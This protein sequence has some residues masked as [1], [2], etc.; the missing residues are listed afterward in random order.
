MLGDLTSGTMFGPADAMNPNGKYRPYLSYMPV[1]LPDRSW[2]GQQITKA[3]TWCSVDL[4][5]GNQALIRPMDFDQ[6]LQLF[7]LL[8]RV[9]FREIEIGFPSANDVEFGFARHLIENGLL[10]NDVWPQV[11]TQARGALIKKTF[12]AIKGAER[13]IVHVYNPTSE[14][15]RRI[16]YRT[17]AAGV[18]ATAVEAVQLIRALADDTDSEIALEYSPES[19]TATEL[20]VALD[21]CN[22][23]VDAWEPDAKRPLILNL[24][25]TVELSTPNI[26]A[27][28]IEWFC[29]NVNSRSSLSISLH[30]HNDRGTAVAAT[31][32][33]L[34]AG[35]DRVEGTLFGNGERTGN[36]DLVTVAMNLF[37]QGINPGLDFREMK[38][39]V[40]TVTE[41]NSIPVHPRHP[42]AGQ[43]VFTAFSGSHQF[44]IDRGLTHRSL[45]SA[46]RWDVPYL[47]I[48]PA[49]IGRDYEADA[50]RI[51]NQ[52]GGYGVAHVLR[53]QY[54]WH[55][56]K[57]L[58]REFTDTVVKSAGD[59]DITDELGARFQ[60]EYIQQENPYG[61]V[62]FTVESADSDTD[63]VICCLTV[64]SIA[65]RKLLH[66]RGKSPLSA[67]H[68]ALLLSGCIA[69]E[70]VSCHKHSTNTDADRQSIAYVQIETQD[71]RRRFGAGIDI[72]A[73]RATAKALLS[74]LNRVSEIRTYVLP[75]FKKA[76]ETEYHCRIPRDMET[77]FE[78]C[79]NLIPNVSTSDLPANAIWEAFRNE[80]VEPDGPIRFVD[81]QVDTDHS[82]KDAAPV[83]CQLKLV[84]DGETKLVYGK[85]RG[86]IEACINA[87]QG[88]ELGEQ[89]S[90]LEVF[91]DGYKAQTTGENSDVPAI[92]FVNIAVSGRGRRYGV[93]I[94]SSTE[95]AEVKA[96]I[97]ALNRTLQIRV[98]K[99]EEFI[100]L[101]DDSFSVRIP[102]GMQ[103][104]FLSLMNQQLSREGKPFSTKWVWDQFLGEF[105]D[106][107]SP[108]EFVEFNT[109]PSDEF[110]GKKVCELVLKQNGMLTSLRGVGVGALDAA[111]NAI[112]NGTNDR[113]AYLSDF[114]ILDFEE[115]AKGAGTNAEAIAFVSIDLDHYAVKYGVG[116]HQ[117]TATA[118]VKALIAAV[119][120]SYRKQEYCEYELFEAMRTEFGCELPDEMYAEF[121]DVMQSLVGPSGDPI[122]TRLIWDRFAEEY[123][124]RAVPY[125]VVKSIT[126]SDAENNDLDVC[127]LALDVEGKRREGVG[128]GRNAVA[129]CQDALS[130]C[131]F[132]NFEMIYFGEHS[133]NG[134]GE[135]SVAYVQ[136]EV[137]GQRR[138]FGVGIGPNSDHASVKAVVSAL[139]RVHT[140]N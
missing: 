39:I 73:N 52:S 55:V 77:E 137:T 21:V 125:K 20:R 104:E 86:T 26:Y 87:V 76:I 82:I 5:D 22:A 94:D 80:F 6:K 100:K 69:F 116:I 11:L 59:T 14:Q 64:D 43:L 102:D 71:R 91:K 113:G 103:H 111:K 50:I 37:S 10:L 126:I 110:A 132:P 121:T 93:G 74:A 112:M 89:F 85:G 3:P 75:D 18:R 49:D 25:A 117:D 128:R 118:R 66:G 46:V 23:V 138:S 122:P 129:A 15:Q 120:R 130:K 29:R 135:E 16:V 98:Q 68:D 105:V 140:E 53:V 41:C 78:S 38:Q 32:L 61:F 134:V 54:D 45:T 51:N 65:E 19:F 107:I 139:N 127:E 95:I 67:C 4:R 33:G 13:A 88:A 133:R 108:Y 12:D 7:E 84:V 63:E 17:D 2:P 9:G 83:T 101:M 1:D 136:I 56:P 131:G 48:D 28:Q 119:N 97:S 72:N 24:P 27:D 90:K 60:K 31:E 58:T 36:V 115:S 109:R 96:V 114:R 123:L 8:V 106:R 92:A 35:A 40:R 99:P 62:D 44:A 124:K 47:P 79:M 70:I 57:A 34:L 30:T 42:Y 81:G